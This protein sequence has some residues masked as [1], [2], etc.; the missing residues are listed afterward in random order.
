MSEEHLRLAVLY[1]IAAQE[2]ILRCC[3]ALVWGQPGIDPQGEI[4]AQ[5]VI[6]TLTGEEQNK[7]REY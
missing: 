3:V 2:Q 4:T 7:W 6:T 5:F 1:R